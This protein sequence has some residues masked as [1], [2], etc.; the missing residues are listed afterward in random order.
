MPFDLD[1]RALEDLDDILEYISSFNRSAADRLLDEFFETF[2][3]IGGMPNQGFRRPE[4]TSKPLRFKVVGNHL[5]AY[6]P[7][8]N[9]VWILAIIWWPP[10]PSRNR[11]RPACERMR[12]S[13]G[14][15]PNFDQIRGP[16][17]ADLLAQPQALRDTHAALS[18]AHAFA[19]IARN[20]TPERYSR[21]VLTGMGGSLFALH[22]LAIELAAHGWTPVLLETSELVHTYPSLLAPSTLVV[23]VS[24]SGRSAETLRLLERNG[25]ATVIAV[26]NTADSPLAAQAHHVVLTAAGSE[27]SVSCKTYVSTLLALSTLGAALRGLDPPARL[28]QLV[29]V[30]DSVESYLGQWESHVEQ[31]AEL[32][33]DVRDIFLVGRGASLAAAYAG[34]LIAKESAHFHAEGMSSAAFR[35]GPFEM[36]DAGVFVA[37]FA[38]DSHA[39]ALNRGLVSDIEATPARAVLFGPD[40]QNAAC[41]LPAVSSAAV[42]IVEIL[43]AQMITL[44]LAALAGREPGRFERATK[45]TAIE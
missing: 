40:A 29:E 41:R 37:V 23:A 9:P 7:E 11:R 19:E 30:P 34:A 14:M 8:Q 33:R 1:P 31:F 45:I 17:L 15:S 26:T 44:A 22:P 43:P 21:V 18:G 6:A 10:Q 39:E 36:L 25:G 5:V 32:L 16:Y 24:Q 42:P 20:C 35:H 3:S 28:G 38:G 27:Y 4:L 2:D 12:G 13:I